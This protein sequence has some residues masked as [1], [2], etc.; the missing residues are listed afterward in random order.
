MEAQKNSK[1]EAANS[2]RMAASHQHLHLE[3]NNKTT[4]QFRSK[5]EASFSLLA[6]TSGFLWCGS[7]LVDGDWYVCCGSEDAGEIRLLSCMTD[8]EMRLAEMNRKI[9]L[10]NRSMIIGLVC[11]MLTAACSLVLML[12]WGK[13]FMKRNYFRAIF[14]EAILEQTENI[15]LI[16]M[17]KAAADAVRKSLLSL[18]SASNTTAPSDIKQSRGKEEKPREKE[19]ILLNINVDWDQVASL[20]NELLDSIPS[21]LNNQNN[22][23]VD[24]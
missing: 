10:K 17:G 18:S 19:E 20:A 12:P 9:T 8:G 16:E 3:G 11:I 14:E 7:V 2:L 4:S 15:L 22:T 13:W 6:A 1:E 5:G 24:K 23:H 21:G